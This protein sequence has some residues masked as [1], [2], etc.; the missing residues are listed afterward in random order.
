MGVRA[1]ARIIGRAVVGS[2]PVLMLTGP[3]TAT[4]KA[5]AKAA[6]FP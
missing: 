4:P 3:I 6:T 5:L 1:R 2:D